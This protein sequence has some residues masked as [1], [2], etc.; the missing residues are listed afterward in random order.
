M[1]PDEPPDSITMEAAMEYFTRHKP[2]VF[3]VMLGETDE[4]AHAR[5]YDLYLE[6]ARRSDE[7]IKRLW[8][9]A[10][11]IPQYAGRTA[12]VVTTD[13]GRGATV[14]DWTS[15]GAK[16]VGAD[17]WWAAAMGPGVEAK[18][19]AGEGEVTQGQTAA[20]VAALVGEDWP[21]AEPKAAK[22]LPGVGAGR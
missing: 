17:G 12:L 1:W 5:R 16:V 9:T 20:T 3:W 21:K 13:H 7:F 15:H 6:S 10:Q 14:A 22:P 11:S 18:G 4:W 19:V 8:G 2:R